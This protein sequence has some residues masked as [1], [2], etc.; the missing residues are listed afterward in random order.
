VLLA[1]DSGRYATFAIKKWG[2]SATVSIALFMLGSL[3]C[4]I[5]WAVINNTA[6]YRCQQNKIK[7]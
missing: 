7:G 4:F 1:N 5:I 2:A 6:G 3:F